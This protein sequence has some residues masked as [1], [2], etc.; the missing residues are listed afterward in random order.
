LTGYLLAHK[1]FV[2]APITSHTPLMPTAFRPARIN[3]F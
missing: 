3:G 1:V 2:D